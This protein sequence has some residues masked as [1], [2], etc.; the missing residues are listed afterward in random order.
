[1]SKFLIIKYSKRL[2]ESILAGLL[3]GTNSKPVNIPGN[4]SPSSHPNMFMSANDPFIPNLS[5]SAGSAKINSNSFG[6][7]ENILFQPSSHL[8]SSLNDG[9]GS[10]ISP[11]LR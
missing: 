11:D 2:T 3:H 9:L 5:G 6:H 1:M 7:N 4:Y 8:V 10:S